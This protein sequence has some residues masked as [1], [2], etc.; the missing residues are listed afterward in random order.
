MMGIDSPHWVGLHFGQSNAEQ[1]CS[2]VNTLW[3]KAR[4]IASKI[5]NGAE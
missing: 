5:C 3:A 2:G 1:N 4:T